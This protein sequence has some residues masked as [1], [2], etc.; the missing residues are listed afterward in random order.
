MKTIKRFIKSAGLRMAVRSHYENPHMDGMDHGASHW[1][2]LIKRGD[3][4]MGVYFSM[5]SAHK[6]PP[7]LADVLDCIASDASGYENSNDFESWCDEYGYDSD[8]RKAHRTYRVVERQAMKLQELLGGAL[9]EE[10]LWDTER[11]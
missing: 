9:Y 2:C 1:K 7:K 3:K 4:R 8:S 11:L 6:G 10:L 5:G